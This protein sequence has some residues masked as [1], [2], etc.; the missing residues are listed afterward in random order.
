MLGATAVLGLIVCVLIGAKAWQ[1]HARRI[2]RLADSSKIDVP[3]AVAQR[4]ERG[5]WNPVA[6]FEGHDKQA[7]PKFQARENNWRVVW[8]PLTTCPPLVVRL[9]LL[10]AAGKSMK[11]CEN[12]SWNP[13]DADVPDPIVFSSGLPAGTF[14]ADISLQP[15]EGLPLTRRIDWEL[16]VEE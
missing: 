11:P 8:R 5:V 16:V 3:V 10:D 9:C 1:A 13:R 6:R 14:T 15:I 7:M 4:R 2:R 12:L